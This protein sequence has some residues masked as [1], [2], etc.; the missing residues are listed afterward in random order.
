MADR[1]INDIK[2][3]P[4]SLEAEQAVLGGIMLDTGAWERVSEA[5]V[6]D[7][8]YRD[9][10]RKIFRAMA[11][12]AGEGHPIDA[13]TVFEQL[14]REG[15]A[16]GVGGLSYLAEL[17][18]NTPSA[19]NILSYANILRER[20]LLR[21]MIS[22]AHEIADTG[23]FP[24]GLSAN[25]L[26]DHAEAKMLA[27]AEKR[28]KAD[29]GP[30]AV[31]GMLKNVVHHLEEVGKTGGLTGL[32][33]GFDD[34]DKE[35]S[36][37]QKGDLIIVAARPSMGKTTFA[38]N[39]CENAMMRADKPVL[40]FSM[41]MPAE[42]LIMRSIASL[43]SIDFSKVRSGQLD[44]PDWDRVFSVVAMLKERNNLYIDDTAGLSPLEVRARARRLH[45]EHGGLSLIMV[46]YLQ[47]M[48]S[49]GGSE[50]RTAEISEISR[51]LKALA[52][53]LKVPLIALSQLN[54]SLEQRT[55]KRPV[56]ADLRESG[57]IEQDADVILC[58]YRD[59]VYHKDKPDNKGIAEILIRKQRNGPIGD[60]QLTFQG[61]YTRFKNFA[62][63]AGEFY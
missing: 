3:P 9:D 42:Q 50:N 58:I 34:L 1:D 25:L 8:F 28:T 51:S 20:A 19:A 30:R 54:R 14:E 61:R 6:A 46:D 23:Y 53:E 63:D 29:T 32:S 17:A 31:G 44:S 39:L 52:K 21:E 36:G 2:A 55:D 35:T 4:H 16:D 33:T 7:D 24:K 60:I 18:K 48:Q 38:M 22:A 26:L 59:E 56:M 37:L 49:D 62:P 57:A 45:R 13:V 15:E 47:L 11:K 10:H 12:L 40:V 27:I 43:G 41:E 5:V